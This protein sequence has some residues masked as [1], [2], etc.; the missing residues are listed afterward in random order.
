MV[1]DHLTVKPH[2]ADC[3]IPRDA[4]PIS[5]SKR[6]ALGTGVWSGYDHIVVFDTTRHGIGGE[7][8]LTVFELRSAIAVQTKRLAIPK[9]ASRIG[10]LAGGMECSGAEL[11]CWTTLNYR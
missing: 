9:P 7:W 6:E 1:H 11:S 8:R 10:G 5:V 2:D 4:T 3:R